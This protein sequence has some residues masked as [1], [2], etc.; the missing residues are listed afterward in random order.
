MW[1]QLTH[2][3]R[4][5]R[6]FNRSPVTALDFGGAQGVSDV[7]SAGVESSILMLGEMSVLTAVT[8][9]V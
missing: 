1:L 7:E 9:V 8:A 3:I 2:Q 4:V 5:E 6:F